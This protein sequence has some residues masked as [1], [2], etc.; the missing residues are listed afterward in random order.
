[1]W[2]LRS[3]KNAFLDRIQSNPTMYMDVWKLIM[4]EVF[5]DPD[6][7]RRLRDWKSF[8][9]VCKSFHLFVDNII[10]FDCY[11][12]VFSNLVNEGNCEA[13]LWFMSRRGVTPLSYASSSSPLISVRFD[14]KNRMRYFSGFHGH[15]EVVNLI[16]RDERFDPSAERQCLLRSSV[17]LQLY[18]VVE[19]LLQHEKVDPS[20]EDNESLRTAIKKKD[21]KMVAMLL[22]DPRVNASIASPAFNGKK[23]GDVKFS[24]FEDSIQYYVSHPS[25]ETSKTD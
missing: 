20:A 7:I 11:E 8:R 6:P 12:R 10:P 3:L 4:I 1:M 24:W 21:D 15:E 17:A 14:A 22:M 16:I 13:I 19:L 9:T 2:I 18:S 23:K 25:L 5:K